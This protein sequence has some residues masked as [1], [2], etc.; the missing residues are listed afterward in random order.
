MIRTRKGVKY[1]FRAGTEMDLLEW[2]ESL[3][4]VY[5][6]PLNDWYTVLLAREK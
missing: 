3:N 1:V 5:D 4:S 6:E 2:I